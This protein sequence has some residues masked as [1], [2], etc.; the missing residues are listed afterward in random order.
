MQTPGAIERVAYESVVDLAADGVVYAELRFAPSLNIERGMSH[1]EV[2]EAALEGMRRGSQDTGTA[3][4][5]I[6]DAMRN[7]DGFT[8]GDFDAVTRRAL[9]A[10]FGSAPE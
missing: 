3:T 7:S 2:L 9:A 6:V 8:A 5:L 4:G 1:H 10:A